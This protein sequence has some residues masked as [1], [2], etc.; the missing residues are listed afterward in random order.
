[1]KSSTSHASACTHTHT[2]N[3]NRHEHN[4]DPRSVALGITYT[5]M[6]E[7]DVAPLR[8]RIIELEAQHKA[9]QVSMGNAQ[10]EYRTRVL[11][12]HDTAA[13]AQAS[14]HTGGTICPIPVDSVCSLTVDSVAIYFRIP[15]LHK[16]CSQGVWVICGVVCCVVCSRGVPC[17][18]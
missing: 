5:H 8:D 9:D 3:I 13:A 10:A 4:L 18:T 6:Q 2:V 16:G 14:L 17:D 11:E 12:A 7:S 1:M 15:E